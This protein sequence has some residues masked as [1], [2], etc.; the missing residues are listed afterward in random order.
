MKYI[1]LKT[2]LYKFVDGASSRCRKGAI[3]PIEK[4]DGNGVWIR[5]RKVLKVLNGEF[6][7]VNLVTVSANYSDRR[8]AG[9]VAKNAVES[10]GRKPTIRSKATCMVI[11]EST[12]NGSL[13]RFY[14]K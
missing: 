6:H 2:D 14:Y 10:T 12:I 5:S 11:V 1:R 9:I 3:F 7:P 13:N 4:Q 8:E